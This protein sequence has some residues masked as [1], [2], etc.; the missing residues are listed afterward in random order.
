LHFS[1]SAKL[2]RNLNHF[3]HQHGST[4]FFTLLSTL[5]VLFHLRSGSQD[6]VI[7]TIT[8]DREAGMET[9]FGSFVNCL[10]LRNLLYPDQTFLDVMET[11]RKSTTDAYA[12]QIPFCKIVEMLAPDRDLANNPLFRVSLV[13]RNIP[14]TH[15]KTGGLEIQL[16]PLPVNRAVSEVDMSLYMQEVGGILSGYFEYDNAIF[17]HSTMERLADD[18]VRLLQEVIAIPNGRLADF[19]TSPKSAGTDFVKEELAIS[20]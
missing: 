10:P 6:I 20:V 2:T 7:G 18:F 3:S 12:H 17:G 9:V 8:G 4:L 15:M 14:F 1:L 11:T 16:S 5:N 13:L 19:M